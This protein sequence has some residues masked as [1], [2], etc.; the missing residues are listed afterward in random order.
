MDNI[1]YSKLKSLRQANHLTQEQLANELN[2]R[3]HLNES[4][5]TISQFENNK[6]IPDLDRLINIADYFH[7]SLDFL[8]CSA[9]KAK[10]LEEV[11]NKSFFS[12]NLRKL[13]EKNN[14]SQCELSKILDVSNGAISKWENGQR[15]P[16]LT[17]L[18]KIATYFDVS[19]DYL[20]RD[21]TVLL[22]SNNIIDENVIMTYDKP[23][24]RIKKL[25]KKNGLSQKEFV[26]KFNEKYGYSDSEATISQY[27]NN[28]RTPE[29]DK[30]V[31]IANF[32]NVTLDYIMCRT[33]IDSDMSIYNKSRQDENKTSLSFS[34]PQ[35]ALSFIL[36]QDMVADFGGYDLDNM[37]DDEIMEMADDIADMLK[38]I[39]RKHK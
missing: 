37:S 18:Q 23:G 25:I 24:D 38:I 1:F 39:S 12:H 36:K 6:R 19:Y 3:Y 31:K 35:E 26:E 22:N 11:T 13:R 16:D 34:T 9:N 14:L 33:D 10:D 30:M 20:L 8:C 32:F 5:A 21:R 2:L 29:I 15:E 27:V 4:K 28:K 17:T 7:I